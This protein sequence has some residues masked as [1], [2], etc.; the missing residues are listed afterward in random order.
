MIKLITDFFPTI[1][2]LSDVDN[3]NNYE[4]KYTGKV[5]CSLIKKFNQESYNLFNSEII[6]YDYEWNFVID[7]INYSISQSN[8]IIINIDDLEDLTEL[9]ISL[10]IFKKGINVI[11]FNE[12][13]F[14]KNIDNINLEDLL[15]I[16]SNKF[17]NGIIFYNKFDE[18]KSS[19]SYIGYNQ[20]LISKN[21]NEIEYK[22][23]NQCHFT[24]LSEF[25]FSPNDFNLN[26]TTNNIALVNIINKIYFAFILVHIFDKS[27]FKKNNINLKISGFKTLE[28]EFGFDKL[29]TDSLQIYEKVFNWIYSEKN[30]I[31]DK[32]GI[33]RNILSIY[34]KENNIEINEN[35]FNSILSANNT[36]IKGNISKYIEA[37]NKIHEQVEQVS[38]KVN[39]SLETFYSNF[40]K[41]I[42][43]FITFYLTIFVL[44]VYTKSDVTSLINKEATIM[45]LGLLLLSFLFL[46]FS[47][48]ILSLEK[49]RINQKY[50]NIKDR[51]LDLLLKEDIDIILKN[52][53]EYNDEIEFLDKRKNLYI[54]LWAS[55]LIIFLVVLFTTSDYINFKN[56]K[57]NKS[58]EKV[59]PCKSN[60]NC[61]KKNNPKPIPTTAK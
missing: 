11:I 56:L 2:I 61:Y 28:F 13:E 35:T 32:I 5:D 4:L 36:Y 37:R 12:N 27:E 48:W 25:K 55:T 14:I 49:K 50:N 31:E 6:N 8:F 46:L 24:N 18:T 54:K 47:I 40:Q 15:K 21:I 19:S 43:V 60:K 44:K 58:I 38:N 29:K 53:N 51:S 57:N 10:Q 7:E 39:S 16:F 17:S 34:L 3:L 45:A 52:D 30:K 33:A 42:F 1:N 41:S 23:S 20:K 26:E 22:I 59:E 9:N